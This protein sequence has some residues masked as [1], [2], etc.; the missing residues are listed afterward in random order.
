MVELNANIPLNKYKN[1][2]IAY[3][4]GNFCFGGNQNPADKDTMIFQQPFTFKNDKLE[5]NDNIKIIPASI[6]SVTNRNNYQPTI[7]E[8]T[9]KKRIINKVN[10]SSSVFKI[11]FN[12]DGT[13][14]K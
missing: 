3:S 7:A 14:K 9:T 1:A 8:G 4:L 12:E 10:Q 5:H 13:L 11:A 2:Y 6:S